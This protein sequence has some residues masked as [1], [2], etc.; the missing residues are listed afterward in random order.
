MPSST[1]L[2]LAST[3]TSVPIE[4]C[5]LNSCSPAAGTKPAPF[6][7]SR[8]ASTYTT[9]TT[10]AA[11][12]SYGTLSSGTTLA[13]LHTSTSQTNYKGGDLS[14]PTRTCLVS[15]STS[16]S[17]SASNIG[18]HRQ[19]RLDDNSY[20]RCRFFIRDDTLCLT[21]AKPHINPSCFFPLNLLLFVI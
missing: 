11:H 8:P 16:A 2:V 20:T 17:T 13:I 5:S 6:T 10:L 12:C 15:A 4:M 18:T 3:S 9:T 14:T 21:Y 7:N 1:A 19:R